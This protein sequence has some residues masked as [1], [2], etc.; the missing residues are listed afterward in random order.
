MNIA[1]TIVRSVYEFCVRVTLERSFTESP[2]LQREKN[3]S[4]TEKNTVKNI[5]AGLGQL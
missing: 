4:E 1:A 3:R 5:A 2:E